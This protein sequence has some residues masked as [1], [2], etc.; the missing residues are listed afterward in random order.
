MTH[1]PSKLPRRWA[2]RQALNHGWAKTPRPDILTR[3]YP[4]AYEP[5]ARTKHRIY[6][7]NDDDSSSG[8]DFDHDHD[9]GY[10]SAGEPESKAEYY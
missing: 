2:Q 8:S 9:A 10:N 5:N 6:T 4:R 1:T 7:S 3:E